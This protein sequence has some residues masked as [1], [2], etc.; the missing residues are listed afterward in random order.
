MIYRDKIYTSDSLLP[1][2][3]IYNYKKR[4][5]AISYISLL[6]ISPLLFSY[7]HQNIQNKNTE[8]VDLKSD[9]TTVYV[10]YKNSFF[11]IPSPHQASL[12]IKKNNIPYEKSILNSPENYSYY[13]SSTKKALNIG[14]YGTDLGYKNMFNEHEG[15][16]AFF[17]AIKKLT[18]DLKIEN[19]LNP[20][21]LRKIE[22]NYQNSDSLIS[23]LSYLYLNY[24]EELINK[25][26]PEFASLILA[27]GYIESLYLLTHCY[28][29]TRKQEIYDFIAEQQN[30]LENLI[31]LLSP[32]YNYS[33]EYITLI[34]ALVDI[35]YDFEVVDFSY[36]YEKPPLINE[37]GVIIINNKSTVNVA[38][39]QL[40][41]II[42]K[43][44]LLRNSIIL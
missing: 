28:S 27:G 35:A 30:P 8:D 17:S 32:Y 13:I 4:L 9:T 42:T 37:N 41:S 21:I 10:K 14:V 23:Y 29:L 22:A 11:C 39:G 40:N 44:N 33:E 3:T 12:I 1:I 26:K 6:F 18:A 25:S 34:D 38:T 19:K 7:C 5:K 2:K 16:A 31:K 15:S 24:N 43:I 20:D 36:I